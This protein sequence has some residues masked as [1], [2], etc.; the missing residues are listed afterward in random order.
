MVIVISYSECFMVCKGQRHVKSLVV[1]LGEHDNKRKGKGK[2]KPEACYAGSLLVIYGL[3]V[4]L[5]S[6]MDAQ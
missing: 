6:L 5:S 2:G 1:Q 4:P 3:P